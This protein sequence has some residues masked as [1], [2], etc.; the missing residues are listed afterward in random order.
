MK[1]CNIDDIKDHDEDDFEDDED[2]F[3]DDEDGFEDDEDGWCLVVY[4]DDEDGWWIAVYWTILFAG[5][6]GLVAECPPALARFSQFT[7]FTI[8]T[9]FPHDD[10]DVETGFSQYTYPTNTTYINDG[11]YKHSESILACHLFLISVDPL[12]K[13]L[14]HVYPLCISSS[15]DSKDFHA[16]MK[17]LFWSSP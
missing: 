10:D 12:E 8:T 13:H 6:N 16:S 2:D 4:D 3:E 9:H 15:L 17:F 1:P 7:R 11:Q 5:S 14:K